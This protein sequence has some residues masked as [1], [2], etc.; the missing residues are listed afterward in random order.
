MRE[1]ELQQ[2]RTY[3]EHLLSPPWPNDVPPVVVPPGWE[4]VGEVMSNAASNRLRLQRHDELVCFVSE[5]LL[6]A[7]DDMVLS[8]A[9]SLTGNKALLQDNQGDMMSPSSPNSRRRFLRRRSKAGSDNTD[10][11]EEMDTLV[12]DSVEDIY[13]Q[14]LETDT[15]PSEGDLCFLMEH[16]TQLFSKEPNVVMV[17]TP[18]VLVGDVHGQIKD[19]KERI[20]ANGGPL[21]TKAYLFLGDYVD[22][23]EASL[24]CISLLVAAKVMF[25][26]KVFLIRGNHESRGTNGCYGFLNECHEKFPR[27]TSDDDED[28]RGDGGAGSS[29]RQQQQQQ[30]GGVLAFGLG[31]HP[32]WDLCNKMFDQLPI[33]AIVGERIF[34]VHGGLSPRAHHLAQIIAC[35]RH[36]DVSVGGILADLTWSDPCTEMEGFCPNHRGCGQLFGEDTTKEFLETSGLTFICR[37]HQCVR[38][39]YVWTHSNKVL[40]LFSAPNYCGQGN[41]GAIMTV[42][43]DGTQDFV[44]YRSALSWDDNELDECDEDA[45]GNDAEVVASP[46]ANHPITPPPK[47]IPMIFRSP[48]PL[49]GGVLHASIQGGTQFPAEPSASH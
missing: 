20:I 8:I 37:A 13:H 15:L 1:H 18:T 41:D 22:R 29:G 34:C 49:V 14:L 46:T 7:E 25:P 44:T 10:T 40:T 9:S 4:A 35:R 17:P 36:R 23:G 30:H 27:I 43:S 38:S 48:P 28:Y 26:S 42:E 24:H 45:S 6:E 21:G 39:G 2:V 19:L 33:A 31:P 16:A 47:V 11:P 3:L 12:R 32:L 5:A